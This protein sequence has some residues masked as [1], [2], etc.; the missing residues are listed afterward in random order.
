MIKLLI[1]SG[2][3]EDAE[4]FQA[5]MRETGE[6]FIQAAEWVLLPANASQ[7]GFGGDLEEYAQFV[8]TSAGIWG[9]NHLQTLPEDRRNTFLHLVG[10]IISRTEE[11]RGSS[12]WRRALIGSI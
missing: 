6:A 3:Q 1:L 5:A 10:P 8:C 4:V 11:E 12:S 9:V 7:L 2:L